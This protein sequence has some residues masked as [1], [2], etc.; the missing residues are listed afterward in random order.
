MT[1][2]VDWLGWAAGAVVR[3]LVPYCRHT[4]HCS[5]SPHIALFRFRALMNDLSFIQSAC[6]GCFHTGNCVLMNVTGLRVPLTWTGTPP[7][8]PEPGMLVRLRIF[9]RD[10]TI[11]A[12]G[13]TPP[14]V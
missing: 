9:F 10:A 11:Y 1:I 3:Y 12:L 5:V 4:L 2:F 6:G 7:A 13:S 14:P 8:V